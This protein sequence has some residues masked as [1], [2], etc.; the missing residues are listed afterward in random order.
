MTMIKHPRTQEEWGEVLR[1]TTLEGVGAGNLVSSGWQL[2]TY[3]DPFLTKVSEP[4]TEFDYDLATICEKMHSTMF[5]RDG[6][7]LSAVQAGIL[8]RIITM[9]IPET[10]EENGKTYDTARPYNF[11]NPEIRESVTKRFSFSEGCLSVPGYF[12][13]RE[14]SDAVLLRYETIHGD[15]KV[16]WFDGLEA[17]VIQH[18]IDHLDG[19]LF[20]D[21]L[22]PLKKKRIG[23][24]IQKTLRKK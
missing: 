23:K 7:G 18:E 5:Y 4:V 16:N 17:F 10:I 14:R 2:L 3:P 1:E 20:I 15:V 6:I 24:K 12:E 22:S 8:K 21:D 19:K 11:I 9:K 13:N